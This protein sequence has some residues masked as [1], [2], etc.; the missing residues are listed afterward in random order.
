[1]EKQTEE[2][3]K[4]ADY[5]MD[6]ADYMYKGGRYI[7]A[8]FMCHLSVEKAL[9]GL[10]FEKLRKIPP[11]SHNLVYLLNE[12]GI[13]PPENPGMFIVK[14]GEASIPT[15][16]PENLARLQQTYSENVVKSILLNGRE[17]I[18]WIKEKL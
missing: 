12:I 16:Y 2:W 13:K 11:K 14:L 7:Y 15:R 5:D 1:M 17:V 10:Y 8:V 9:K 6:T 18:Q 3:L 4:Q